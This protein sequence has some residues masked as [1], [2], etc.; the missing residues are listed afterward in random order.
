MCAGPRD[1]PGPASD[2]QRL[3]SLLV[4]GDDRHVM[5]AADEALDHE[6]DRLPILH[7]VPQRQAQRANHRRVTYKCSPIQ[8]I[9]VSADE[10]WQDDSRQT[11]ES[12]E[13]AS[14]ALL[15]PRYTAEGGHELL[16]AFVWRDGE[17]I[18]IDDRVHVR[19]P[20]PP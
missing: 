19:K 17:E 20:C 8:V 11:Y 10:P 13:S 7:V 12:H 14:A 4:G 6:L 18:R 1:E 2:H 3:E 15:T 16:C 5:G 9:P